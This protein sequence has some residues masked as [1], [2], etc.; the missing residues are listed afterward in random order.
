MK[1]TVEVEETVQHL[2]VLEA[3]SPEQA[4][5]AYKALEG[6]QIKAYDLGGDTSWAQPHDV[7]PAN[8]PAIQATLHVIDEVTRRRAVTHPTK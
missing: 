8:L 5:E 1:Y 6:W 4:L 3:D 2:Y 7:Y